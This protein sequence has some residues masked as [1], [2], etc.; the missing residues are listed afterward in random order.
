MK[1]GMMQ[2]S[3]R[4]RL[5]TAIMTIVITIVTVYVA[6]ETFTIYWEGD[7]IL[8]KNRETFC[9]DPES[10]YVLNLVLGDDYMDAGTEIAAAYQEIR[11]LGLKS[12]GAYKLNSYWFDE[13]QSEDTAFFDYNASVWEGWGLNRRYGNLIWCLELYGDIDSMFHIPAADGSSFPASK[14]GEP[15]SVL[16]SD[17]YRDYFKEG[18]ILHSFNREYQVTGYLEPGG[19]FP[20]SN[21]FGAGNQGGQEMEYLFAVRYE[22]PDP[23]DLDSSISNFYENTYLEFD[24]EKQEDQMQKLDNILQKWGILYQL[25]TVEDSYQDALRSAA[26]SKEMR[27][28]YGTIFLTVNFFVCISIAVVESLRRK[29]EFGI[30]QACGWTQREL[31]GMLAGEQILEKAVSLLIAGGFL[32]QKVDGWRMDHSMGRIME[33]FS[34]TFWQRTVPLLVIYLLGM[35]VFSCLVSAVILSQKNCL[36]MMER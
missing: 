10:V 11:T 21:A 18:E 16:V 22:F 27:V 14:E 7:K 1:Y 6:G 26:E 12:F 28:K 32:I 20:Y 13:L 17:G 25:Q 29:K 30:Y 23:V 34:L 31:N 33:T 2:K 9:A 3:L 35:I 8:Q 24:P 15:L 36:E 4:G 19:Y 5:Y